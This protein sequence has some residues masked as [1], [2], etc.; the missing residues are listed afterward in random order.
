MLNELLLLSGN[1][2]PFPEARVTI[3]QPRIKEIAYI[4]EENFF[5][6]CHFLMFDKNYLSDEDKSGLETLSDFHIFMSVMN[7]SE[8]TNHKTDAIM[9]LTLLFPEYNVEIK[10]DNI[11]LQS[12]KFSS[13]INEKNFESFKS[14]INQIFCLREEDAG[15]GS[16][17]ADPIAAKIAEKIRKGKAKKAKMKSNGEMPKINIFSKYISILSVGLKKDM[18][19]LMNYTVYQL[20][21]EFQRYQLKENYDFYLKAKL[22]GAQD[23]EEVDNWMEDIH[24]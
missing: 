13:S 23:L 12:E 24:P 4:G 20:K 9:V 1:D 6:G 8:S 7:S 2:I 22:A 19:Q 15:E 21:D 10:K 16:N 3:H 11:L 17:P 14:I 5:I 18:N